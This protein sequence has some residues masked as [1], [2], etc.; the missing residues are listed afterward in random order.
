MY[1]RHSKDKPKK[2]DIKLAKGIWKLLDEADFIIGQN[3]K[4]F[5]APKLNTMFLNV[6]L[7]RVS[8]YKQIDTLTIAKQ[9]FAFTSN[10]LEFT[11]G[12][13]CTKFKKL[14][15]GEFPGF[16][17]FIECTLGNP[18]AWKELEVYNKYDVLSTEEYYQKIQPYDTSS[19]NLN[20]YDNNVYN[21]IC[22]CG[23]TELRNK[24]YAYTLTGKFR[25]YE[26]KQCGRPVRDNKNMLDKEKRDSLKRNITR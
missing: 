11:S 2:D 23:S 1:Q 26:C 7:K 15:H 14:K 19:M 9:N 17:L 5:D 21:Y 12:K 22:N 8:P 25:R 6:G 3:V 24:G 10:K 4:R 16:S 20:S 13:Y 18:N